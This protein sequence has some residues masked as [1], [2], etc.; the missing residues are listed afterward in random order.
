LRRFHAVILTALHFFV[1][2]TI[3]NILVDSVRIQVQYW[4]SQTS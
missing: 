2:P 3:A 1:P 4:R